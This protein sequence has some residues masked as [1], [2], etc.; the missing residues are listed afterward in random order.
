MKDTQLNPV[1]GWRIPLDTKEIIAN[2]AKKEQRSLG[3]MLRCL[4]DEALIARKLK[5]EKD[6]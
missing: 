4:V 2:Q 6:I 5:T 1:V 3:N